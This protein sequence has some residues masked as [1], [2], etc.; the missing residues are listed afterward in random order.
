LP[1]IVWI[2]VEDMSAHFG[3]YGETAIETP[4]VDRL[5]AEGVRYSNAFVT[6]P[7]CSACR[8]ALI[9]GMYQ[10]SIGAHHHRSG[11][12]EMKIHLPDY[13]TPTPKLL[14]DA[15]YSTLNLTFEEFMHSPEQVRQ[16]ARVGIAKTDTT[17]SGTR[18]CTIACTGWH[19]RPAGR[20]FARSSFTGVS[21][22]GMATGSAGRA[23]WRRSSAAA[24]RRGM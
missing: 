1:N 22:A 3:C 24:P 5:A 19:A 2:V 6:A 18:R 12:G 7:V 14:H 11:R 17:S 10:S 21:F 15:G 13:V 20:S 16:D 8:S 9:T 4:N 23:R